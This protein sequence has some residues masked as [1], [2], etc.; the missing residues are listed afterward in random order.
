METIL[1]DFRF[2]LRVLRRSPLVAI[3]IIAMLGILDGLLLHSVH[4]PDPQK[5]VFVWS[6]DAQ[7]ALSNVS[8]ADYLDFR[9]KAKTL[10]DAA[11]WSSTSLVF[12]GGERP[13]QLGGARVTANFFRT[14]RVKPILGRTFLPDEDGID[15]PANAAR[16]VVISYR[17]WQE[18]LGADPNILGR[19]VHIEATPYTIIG[20]M[21][22][23]FQFWWR[24]HDLWI[25][26]SL[27]PNERD[28]RNLT[29]VARI[30]APRSA[31]KAEMN[32]LARALADAYP[33][34]DKGW[35][36]LVERL[37]ERFFNRTFRLRLLLASAAV[38]LVLLIACANVTGLLLARS[39]ARSQ[40]FA[41][42]VS[43]GAS[44]WR[45][46]RQ[47]LSEAA[48]L[49]LA[50]GIAGLAIAWVLIR[51]IPALVPSAVIPTG[52]IELNGAVIFFCLAASAVTCLLVG[53]AP[54]LAVS[55]PGTQTTLRSARTTG[56]GRAPQHLRQALVA[57]EIA[58]AMMLLASAWLM[59]GSLRALTRLDPGFDP[60]TVLTLRVVVPN[61]KYD[62]PQEARFFA[63]ARERIA[64]L[65]GVESA[66]LGTS[67]PNATN[68][69]RVR[70]DRRDS[71][72]EEAQ[73]P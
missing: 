36:V 51:A 68:G 54:A 8:A 43:L 46:G 65:P 5:L 63:Q 10:A 22:P 57:G 9:R 47:L 35:T 45:L 56:P 70:F 11:A 28:Y 19:T 15:N 26:V 40:E 25:P 44:G 49:A 53:L 34:S 1:Q 29:L 4:Y 50:G 3:S 58:V 72:R 69:M 52:S 24:P 32:V 13:R 71:P 7:G 67:L 38:G 27:D 16:S 73:Q 61:A 62:G 20:V 48:L 17:L 41:I 14:L 42:R 66:T 59:V 33:K 21:P 55:Q 18:D 30:R 37:E 60:S 6:V 31:V 23:N 12:R 39:A 2:G 64:G